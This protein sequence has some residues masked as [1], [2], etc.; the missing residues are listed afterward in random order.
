MADGEDDFG[1]VFAFTQGRVL[2]NQF[3]LYEVVRTLARQSEDPQRF[4]AELFD[5]V[6]SRADQLMV[7][8]EKSASASAREAIDTFFSKVRQNL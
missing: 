8:G 1:E 6:C 5:R 2:A 7:P 4:A 3:I